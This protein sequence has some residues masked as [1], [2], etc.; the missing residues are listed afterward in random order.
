M[1]KLKL[2]LQLAATHIQDIDEKL[3]SLQAKL[4]SKLPASEKIILAAKI[5]ALHKEKKKTI[6]AI[7]HLLQLMKRR[8][9]QART[10]LEEYLKQCK[11]SIQQILDFLL[12]IDVERLLAKN[13][14]CCY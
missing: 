12:Q 14:C 6:Q 3:F 2:F 9:K 5:H 10:N 1:I 13:Q 11:Q 8:H 7:K 4:N